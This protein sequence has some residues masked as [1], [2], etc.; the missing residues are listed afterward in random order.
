MSNL[1]RCFGVK[2]VSYVFKREVAVWIRLNPFVSVW[3]RLNPFESVWIARRQEPGRR[4]RSIRCCFFSTLLKR[5]QSRD[6]CLNPCKNRQEGRTWLEL[7]N[8][9]ALEVC[10]VLSPGSLDR[11]MV[12]LGLPVTAQLE[13]QGQKRVRKTTQKGQKGSTTVRK[14]EQGWRPECDFLKVPRV[15]TGSCQSQHSGGLRRLIKAR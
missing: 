7:W 3:I 12:R 1:F 4:S 15:D 5:I 10:G 9:G 6:C 14:G 2:T 11:Y 8:S 13:S